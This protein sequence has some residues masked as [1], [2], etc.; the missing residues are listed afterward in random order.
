M[1]K[2]ALVLALGLLA[3]GQAQVPVVFQVK[4]AVAV[5]TVVAVKGGK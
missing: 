4:P 2:V 1:K 3:T 5:V